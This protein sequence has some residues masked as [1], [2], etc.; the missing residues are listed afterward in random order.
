M[1][2]SLYS[3]VIICGGIA[4]VDLLASVVFVVVVIIFGMSAIVVDSCGDGVT[5]ATAA[6]TT[7]GLIDVISK[8]DLL[9]FDFCGVCAANCHFEGSPT[10]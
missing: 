5:V 2:F 1:I 6:A 9:S 4:T 3:I 10:R 7:T 8:V